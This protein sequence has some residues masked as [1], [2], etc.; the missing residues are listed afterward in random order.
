MGIFV[1]DVTDLMPV[2][3]QHTEVQLSGPSRHFA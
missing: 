3:R 2:M 1:T